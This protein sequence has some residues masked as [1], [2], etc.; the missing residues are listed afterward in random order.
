VY[1]RAETP[2]R[3]T[4]LGVSAREYTSGSPPDT[5][6]PVAIRAPDCRY[7]VLAYT[8]R[9]PIRRPLEQGEVTPKEADIDADGVLMVG[10][11]YVLKQIPRRFKSKL[12]S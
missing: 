8:E 9:A 3:Y 10:P 6:Q 11:V 1:S 7:S 2:N 5:P 4:L 12:E